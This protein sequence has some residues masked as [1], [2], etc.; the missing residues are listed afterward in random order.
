MI[1]R[2]REVNPELFRGSAPS[3]EDVI[4]LNKKI[5]I[6]KI[7]SLDEQAGNHID[8]ACKLLG[9]KHIMCPIDINKKSTLI[10]FL[11]HD[12]YKLFMKDGPTYTHCAEGKDRTGLAIALFRCMY[13]G[14]TCEK[15]LEEAFKLGFGKGVNHKIIKLYM[16]II[17]MVCH[18]HNEDVK[19]KHKKNKND[20]SFNFDGMGYDVVSNQREYPSDYADYTLGGWEQ[21]SMWSPYSDYRVEPWPYSTQEV[22]WD[23]QYHS[24]QDYGLDDSDIV[25]EDMPTIPQSGSFDSNT[26][27]INGAGP[28]FVGSGFV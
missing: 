26:Q 4:F 23:D 1:R 3:V 13:D 5:G 27:G 8:R 21:Q 19:H 18:C 2:F 17:E 22:G 11:K 24:R 9:I 12:L 15:A 16:N 10:R 7:V 20:V 25:H 6:K 28:S 14:W